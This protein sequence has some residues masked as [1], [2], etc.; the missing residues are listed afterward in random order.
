MRSTGRATTSRSTAARS[1]APAASSTSDTLFYQGTVL[2]DMNPADMLAALNVPR[3]EARQA[4]ARLGRAARR[5]LEGAAG[6]RA[7]CH[8]RRSR[9]RCSRASPSA[10]ASSRCA[11]ADHDVEEES[12]ARSYHDEEIGTDAFVAEIDDPGALRRRA[13]RPA[14]PARAARSPPMSASR[15]RGTTI[16]A[17][18]SSPATS[19]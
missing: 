13:L 1:A 16:C 3:G 12:L 17:R 11:G 5:D 19:S 14:T 7:P 9:A 10:W 15:D 2:V 18:C 4:R 8:R 6:R